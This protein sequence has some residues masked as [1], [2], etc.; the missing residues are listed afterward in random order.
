MLSRKTKH[1]LFRLMFFF[2]GILLFYAPFAY[3]TRLLLYLTDSSLTADAHRICLRMPF[4]WSLQPWMYP[5]MVKN[6]LYLVG[7]VLL[8]IIALFL[9]PLFCGWLCPAGSMTE[10]L[11]KLVPS[12]VKLSLGGKINPSP[13]RYG[14]LL[15][16]TLSP[17]LGGYICCTFCNFTMMQHL[18]NAVTGNP[19]GLTAWASFTIITF[20]LWFFVLGIF[21]VGGRGF[22]NFLCPAGAMQGLFHFLGRKVKYSRGISIDKKRCENC[23]TCVTECPAWAISKEKVLNR[24]A[25]NLCKDC[26]T[27]CPNDAIVYQ[28]Q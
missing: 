14:V 22:C 24:H 28:P 26:L 5:V 11:S 18:V 17:F 23:N 19:Y 2:M 9:G 4:E 3:L 27:V 13:I 25:C 15:A 12:K 10:F 8:P 16:M 1:L 7:L 21:L 6:P 20:V